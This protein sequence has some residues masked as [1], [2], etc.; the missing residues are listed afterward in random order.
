[1]KNSYQFIHLETYSIT[2]QKKSN[3]PSAEAVAR[4]CQRVENSYPHIVEPKNADLLYGMQPL[5]AVSK[6]KQLVETIRDSLGRKIRKDAQIISFGVAS[7]KVES[8]PENWASEEVVKW[9]KDTEL[10]LKKRF[11]ESFVS[12]N[13]HIDEQFC[14]LHFT[15]IPQVTGDKLDLNSF[16]PGLAAQ[17]ALKTSKKASKD[18][19][20]KEAMR[21]FQ[22]EYFKSVGLKNGQLRYGPR[23]KR[24]TRKE[25][26][27]QKRY[28]QL[29]SN[30]FNEQSDLISSLNSKLEKTKSVLAKF[31]SSKLPR[32]KVSKKTH[33]E[34]SL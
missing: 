1:M 7:I 16:H 11:G 33:E 5:E 23:R 3:R 12:L 17:R 25:W 24:L 21:V 20:Y 14:H 29:I 34:L 10:F 28:G 15:L 13:K 19:A 4:E 32:K 31:I 30:I 6:V 22:D 27:A 8:T 2:P 9:V 18:Q 26:Y